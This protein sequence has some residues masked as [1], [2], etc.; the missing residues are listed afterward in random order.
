MSHVLQLR[1]LDVAK[2][3]NKN[4]VGGSDAILIYNATGRFPLANEILEILKW[5]SCFVS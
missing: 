4:N 2:H 5:F 1:S 3:K